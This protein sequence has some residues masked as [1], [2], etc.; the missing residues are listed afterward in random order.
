MF[1]FF[2]E[3]WNISFGKALSEIRRSCTP[4]YRFIGP[5]G[6]PVAS[7]SGN[8]EQ[9]NDRMGDILKREAID[10]FG[11]ADRW[12]ELIPEDPAPGTVEQCADVV[13]FLA[14]VR[15]SHISGTT[16]TVDGG[17]SAR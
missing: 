4:T 10:Q 6:L 16:L 13:T 5:V 2:R 14:S 7:L 1:L 3:L 17:A 12:E 15:A 11:D 9:K 8:P